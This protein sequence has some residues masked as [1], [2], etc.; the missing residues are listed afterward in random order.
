MK[1][2]ECGTR[3]YLFLWSVALDR[4]YPWPEMLER[5]TYNP[6]TDVVEACI[7][8]LRGQDWGFDRGFYHKVNREGSVS[9]DILKKHGVTQEQIDKEL[10]RWVAGE[11]E[12]RTCE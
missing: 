5:A 11:D 6:R 12:K 8:G 2:G 3:E 9:C 1:P 4:G 10:G 7:S